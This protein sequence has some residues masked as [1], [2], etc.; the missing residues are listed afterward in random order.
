M[1]LPYKSRYNRNA[2]ANVYPIPLGTHVY[3]GGTVALIERNTF[4]VYIFAAITRY[5]KS[6]LI[7]NWYTAVSQHRGVI[8]LDYLGEHT[9]SKLPNFLSEDSNSMCIP[10]LIE[11]KD[12]KFK[13]SQFYNEGDWL[14]LTF[15][16]KGAILMTDL[17]RRVEA[18]RDDPQRFLKMLEDVPTSGQYQKVAAFEREWGF[19]MVMQ[20]EATLSAAKAMFKNLTNQ[21]F[22]GEPQDATYDF[23][24]ICADHPYINI[25]FQLG[26]SDVAKGRAIAGKVLE[27]IR[28]RLSLIRTTPLIVVEE[29]DVLAPSGTTDSLML[30][31]STA[32]LIDYV[33]KLQKFNIEIAF[34][35]QDPNRLHPAIVGNRHAMIFGQLPDKNEFTELSRSLVWDIDKNYREFILVQTGVPG[36]QVFTPYDSATMY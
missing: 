20:S 5:G 11:I 26:K 8:I 1:V 25:N 18:H 19:E 4:G 32:Q 2:S 21:R 15:T 12:F 6:T 17:A 9:L 23:G 27:Q 7:K 10:Q 34:V 33:I 13:I 31:S 35:V 22:F 28:R 3:N 30:P 24:Q 36:Y 14:S 16:E 29:A